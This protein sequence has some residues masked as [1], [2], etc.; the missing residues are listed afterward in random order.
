M[1]CVSVIILYRRMYA[2]NLSTYEFTDIDDRN[3]QEAKCV[4]GEFP[5]V[6]ETVMKQVLI[7]RRL[8]HKIRAASDIKV[9]HFQ[10]TRHRL[11]F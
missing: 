8:T 11:H 1:L 2:V 5:C 6:G 10:R 9:T 4:T 7:Q 3:L